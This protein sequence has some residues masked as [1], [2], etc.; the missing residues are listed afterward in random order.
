MGNR[1]WEGSGVLQCLRAR[2]RLDGEEGEITKG[3][4]DGKGP[5]V[6]SPPVRTLGEGL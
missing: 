1:H 3:A 4:E 5:W 6:Q 2:Y